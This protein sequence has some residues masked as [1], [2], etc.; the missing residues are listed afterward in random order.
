MC[1]LLHDAHLAEHLSQSGTEPPLRKICYCIPLTEVEFSDCTECAP[2]IFQMKI[3][4][5]RSE[6]KGVIMYHN[7]MGNNHFSHADS[8]LEILEYQAGIHPDRI[9]VDDGES[10]LSWRGLCARAQQIGFALTGYTDCG[11]PV[12]F[13]LEKNVTTLSLMFGI[14]YAGCF[15]VPIHPSQPE[16]RLQKFFQTL[17]ADVIVT[18]SGYEGKIRNSGFTGRIVTLDDLLKAETDTTVLE[19]IRSQRSDRDSLYGIFTSGSTG[20]PK[21]ITVS[22]RS[23][24]D[25]IGH[26]V[27]EFSFNETDIFGNQAPFDF[28][29]SVKDIYST[30][31]TGGKLVLIR[32]ELFSTPPYLMDYLYE[33]NVTT[34]IWAVSA[35][36][37][38]SALKALKYRHLPALK[39]VLFSGEVMPPKQLKRWQEAYPSAQF[40]NLYGPTEITCN[41]TFYRIERTFAATE[42][43]PVGKAFPGRN[44]WLRREDGSTVTVPNEK[45]EICVS[46]ES[47]SNGYYHNPS[48]TEKHFFT[49][50]TDDGIQRA[51]ATGDLGYYDAE[52]YLYFSGRRD[53]QIKH[54]GHRIEL[55]E[56]EREMQAVEGVSKASCIFRQDKN[57]ILAFYMGNATEEMIRKGLHKTL[58]A[59]MLPNRISRIDRMPLTKNGKIDRTALMDIEINHANTRI[60]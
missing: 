10:Q 55:E 38:L 52:G 31:F 4:E 23:V 35:L 28:D 13:F 9:A 49:V 30:L 22:H 50:G 29:V 51:Y 34:L 7:N 56:I 32:K 24:I 19:R 26:F 33:K 45:G 25:F 18:E 20:N 54:M 53:F 58:P 43:I 21:C 40:I 3:S 17:Q 44:V 48:E 11:M 46:G 37:M 39:N 14:V 47:I 42:K 27:D 5:R 41:C 6:M 60:G 59:Y 15:Y 2:G 57:K 1:H 36:C 8:V 12:P 16:S